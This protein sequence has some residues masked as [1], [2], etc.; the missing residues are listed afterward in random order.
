MSPDVMTTAQQETTNAQAE[1]ASTNGMAARPASVKPIRPKK[2]WIDLDN[3]PHVPF[4]LPII[5]QLQQQGYEIILTARDTYQ[6]CE[7]LN[8]YHLSCE[9]LGKHWGTNRIVKALGTCWRALRL[10]P[11]VRKRKPDL[12]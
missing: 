12:A 2:I 9:V 6:V 1:R 8:F 3:S 4:F 11:V 10:V 5:E 7:L